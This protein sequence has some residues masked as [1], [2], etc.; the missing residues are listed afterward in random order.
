MSER[1]T[2]PTIKSVKVK[3]GS[4][5]IVMITAYDFPTAQIAD[6]AGVD[7]ILVG[8][9]LANVVLGY[10]DTLKV[11]TSEIAYHVKAVKNA[12]PQCLLVADMPWL[13]YHLGPNKSVKNASKL[14]R[15]GASAVKLE[16]GE[17]RTDAIASILGA[18]IPVM[19]HLGLTPQSVNAFG[20]FKV[21]GKSSQQREKI[22]RDAHHLSD[23]GCF[24]I[25][26]EGI[27]ADLAQ[28]ITD[29]IPIPTI[30]IGAGKHC[31]GQVLV[32][33]DVTGFKFSNS[34]KFVKTFSD[35]S[36]VALEAV[37]QYKKEVVDGTF[38]SESN[39]YH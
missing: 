32:F 26:L 36:G 9:S 20:G 2:V 30:G 22:L 10:D 34:A 12:K 31:D 8:D 15:A 33:H 27:P 7:I 29:E 19:G 24:S 1:V 4:K 38:P 5:P 17:E 25:V 28:T 35:L 21:Q 16:G 18:E 37:E 39:S 14:I 3:N 23:L 6:K 13:S 11:K